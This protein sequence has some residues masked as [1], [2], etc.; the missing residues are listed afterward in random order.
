M[1]KKIQVLQS[2][3]D[4]NVCK[5][6]AIPCIHDLHSSSFFLEI[7][8]VAPFLISLHHPKKTRPRAPNKPGKSPALALLPVL[9]MG[10]SCAGAFPPGFIMKH[11]KSGG[12][13]PKNLQGESP[14]SLSINGVISPYK[15]TY[16][17]PKYVLRKEFPLFGFAY[18]MRM[19]QV[20]NKCS[21]M[22]V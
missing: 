19:E 12:L 8:F 10:G 4:K 1:P 17:D 22:V 21:Q 18:S 15:W 13:F 6:C 2:A 7:F 5:N 9:S 11:G 14:T 16:K 3:K 20:P